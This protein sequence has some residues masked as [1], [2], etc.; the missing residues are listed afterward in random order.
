MELVALAN[1][2]RENRDKI[3]KGDGK[4][5]LSADLLNKLNSH[6]NLLI[7]RREMNVSFHVASVTSETKEVYNDLLYLYNFIKTASSLKLIGDKSEFAN[8]SKFANLKV[9]ELYKVNAS[10]V[11]GLERLRPKIECL[12]CQRSL[13]SIKDI[14]K[15]RPDECDGSVDTWLELKEICFSH[16]SLQSIDD[17]VKL[18]PYLST[19][20]LSHN[21][22]KVVENLSYLINLKHLNLSF[23]KLTCVPLLSGQVC[24]RLQVNFLQTILLGWQESNF[25]L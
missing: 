11:L 18:V 8:V 25:G 23:N 4:F 7:E 10:T 20:D 2:L 5:T 19:L 13:C 3:T 17:C 24:S 15:R 1:T 21:E 9:L 6:I 16:N 22:L 14:L 12:I